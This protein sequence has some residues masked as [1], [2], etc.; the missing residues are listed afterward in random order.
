MSFVPRHFKDSQEASF[1][2]LVR[3]AIRKSDMSAGER[4]VTGVLTDLWFHHR[5]S[6]KGY[7]HPS[8]EKIAKKVGVTV[9]TVSR[10]LAMLRAAG[11]AVPLDGIKGGQG[12]ATRYH[13]NI[14]ALMSLCGCDWID[15]FARG[16]AYNCGP[17]VPVSKAEMSRYNRDKM[18]HCLMTSNR[19]EESSQGSEFQEANPDA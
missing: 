3:A 9:K 17:Y 16:F 5:H 18:S 7:I 2:R 19:K 14:W 6:Q 15:E 11:I 4:A 13:I 8:R 10:A 12:K 1:R